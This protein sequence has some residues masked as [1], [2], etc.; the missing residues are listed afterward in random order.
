[1]NWRYVV[2]LPLLLLVLSWIYW[3]HI[4]TILKPFLLDIYQDGSNFLGVTNT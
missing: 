4:L 1:M 2:V 3:W